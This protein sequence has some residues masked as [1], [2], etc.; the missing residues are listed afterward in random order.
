MHL[1]AKVEN[2]CSSAEIL[3]KS[4]GLHARRWPVHVH[5]VNSML[6]EIWP[7]EFTWVSGILY[8]QR[9]FDP[10]RKKAER[11]HRRSQPS[12]SM[13]VSSA[14]FDS[15]SLSLLPARTYCVIKEKEA[16]YIF[17]N[18][19]CLSCLY[20]TVCFSVL[21]IRTYSVIKEKKSWLYFYISVLLSV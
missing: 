19:S 13:C 2:R 9:D 1:I 6:E 20:N 11:F 3:R 7:W 18:Q 17:I 16:D 12:A 15:L 8:K 14:V 4:C 10:N 5:R 21:P